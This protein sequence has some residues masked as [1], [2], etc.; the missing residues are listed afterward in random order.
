M[1]GLCACLGVALVRHSL[2][3]GNRTAP[4]AAWADCEALPG[5][6]PRTTAIEMPMTTAFEVTYDDTPPE[7]PIRRSTRPTS[8][9]KCGTDAASSPRC[10]SAREMKPRLDVSR[11]S[12]MR[13]S[14]S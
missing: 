10:T 2:P 7:A 13:R 5:L 6:I 1:L 9:S 4:E 14:A 12:K 3:K 8:A 11:S